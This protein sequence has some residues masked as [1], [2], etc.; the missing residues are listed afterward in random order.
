MMTLGL[1]TDWQPRRVAVAVQFPWLWIECTMTTV[2]SSEK[3]FKY[4]VSVSHYHYWLLRQPIPIATKASMTWLFFALRLLTESTK[5]SKNKIKI[6]Q[7]ISKSIA[8]SLQE[9]MK[10][11][12]NIIQLYSRVL[13]YDRVICWAHKNSCDCQ[14]F[15]HH[16]MTFALTAYLWWNTRPC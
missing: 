10:F 4:K 1:R 9:L 7:Y 3:L 2:L 13:L 8:S 15:C 14:C 12:H 5:V 11:T 6:K 16:N